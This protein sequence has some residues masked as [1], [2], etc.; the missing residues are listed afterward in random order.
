M[1]FLIFFQYNLK[2]FLILN[3]KTEFPFL[4]FK[5]FNYI[6]KFYSKFNKTTQLFNFKI[7]LYPFEFHIYCFIKREIKCF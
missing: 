6:K 2:L 5:T 7:L 4:I 1:I 3:N